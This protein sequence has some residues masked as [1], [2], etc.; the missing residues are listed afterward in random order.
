MIVHVPVT[1]APPTE[2]V[3][4]E[5]VSELSFRSDCWRLAILFGLDGVSV[6][7]SGKESA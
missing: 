4:V 3:V 7:A 2:C 5:V 1:Y 6:T